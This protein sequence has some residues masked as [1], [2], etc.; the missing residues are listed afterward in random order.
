[1]ISIKGI[2]AFSLSHSFNSNFYSFISYKQWLMLMHLTLQITVQQNLISIISFLL[3]KGQLAAFHWI[4]FD[5]LFLLFVNWS[6]LMN[7]PFFYKFDQFSFFFFCNEWIISLNDDWLPDCASLRSIAVPLQH[8]SCRSCDIW[9]WS[10][11]F[12]FV[13]CSLDDSRWLNFAAPAPLLLL[14]WIV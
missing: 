9:F 13:F 4:C 6:P 10:W 3:F 7:F 14:L 1:M 5:D 12:C 8:G 11:G 2:C